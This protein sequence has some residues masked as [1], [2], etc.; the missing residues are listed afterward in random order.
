[1][2]F[3]YD[4]GGDNWFNNDNW[5]TDAPL[6]DWYGVY[7]N[8]QGNCELYLSANNL[9]GQ[10]SLSGCTSLVYLDVMVNQ[11]TSLD[12][13]GC[14]SLKRLYYHGSRG[15]TIERESLTRLDV[16][17][18]TSLVYLNCSYNQLTSLNVLGCRSLEELYCGDNQ[19]THLDVSEC[20]S[21]VNLYCFTNQLTSLDVSDCT[22]L[23]EL[24]CED[25]LLTSLEVTSCASL[26]RLRCSDN[27]ISQVITDFYDQL[28]EFLYDVRYVGYYRDEDGIL[29]YTDNG[30]GWWYPGEPGKGYHGK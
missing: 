6:N 19:L 5:C 20:T 27:Q 21:L 18:C 17:G 23:E 13:S 12:V 16:S 11:L 8:E 4:T 7:F 28:K 10:G 25:N 29:H 24:Y 30:V 2:Q 9:V 15:H 22:S 1:M 14:T 26:K 3:Y